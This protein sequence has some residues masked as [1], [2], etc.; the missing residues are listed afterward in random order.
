[1]DQAR[2]GYDPV[3]HHSH[4]FPL[5]APGHLAAVAHLFGLDTPDVSHARVLEID[6]SSGGNLVPFAA[7]H[8]QAQVVGLDLSQVQIDQGRR[9]I[10]EL[11]PGNL[12]LIQGDIAHTDLAALGKYDFVICHGVYSWVPENVQRAILSACQ[13]LLA[14]NGIAYLSYNVYPGWKAKEIVRDAMLL[15]GCDVGTPEQR[16][17][18]ARGMIDFLEEVAP[19]NSVLSRAQIRYRALAGTAAEAAPE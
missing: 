17:S 12:N 3:P 18:Y 7:Y 8:P 9:R 16:L 6:C 1:M 10:A 13:T 5:T 2:A 15:R 19:A 14:P 11:G 4:P